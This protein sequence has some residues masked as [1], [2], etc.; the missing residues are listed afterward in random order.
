MV[1]ERRSEI[2]R[3]AIS[4]RRAAKTPCRSGGRRPDACSADDAAKRY[5]PVLSIL[6]ELR[7][8]LT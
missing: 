8:G 7:D 1:V 3:V 2:D 6:L 5:S 4:T